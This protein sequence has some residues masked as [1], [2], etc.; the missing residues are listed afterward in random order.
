MHASGDRYK[1]L[2]CWGKPTNQAASGLT[3]RYCAKLVPPVLTRI[4]PLR[5]AG[6]VSKP[7]TAAVSARPVPACQRLQVPKRHR[8]ARVSAP[9]TYRT[10]LKYR[11]RPCAA[12]TMTRTAYSG[13]PTCRPSTSNMW[14]CK[15]PR[16]VAMAVIALVARNFKR[17]KLQLAFGSPAS[18]S[19]RV[20]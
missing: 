18:Q 12:A 10:K 1:A 17:I 3:G 11:A 6:G 16:A 2:D 14:G 5:S 4:S 13:S 15:R 20:H 7:L 8:A 9:S 19:R